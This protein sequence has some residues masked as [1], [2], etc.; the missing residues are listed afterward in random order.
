MST[1]NYNINS[2]KGVDDMDVVEGLGIDH[3]HA[4]NP[5]INDAAIEAVK[6]TN[7]ASV[8]SRALSEGKSVQEAEKE[9][10]KLVA[11]GEKQTRKLLSKVQKQRGYN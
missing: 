11:L 9:A 3:S 2:E 8:K 4:Y 6:K 7:Y 10:N 5:S 1:K